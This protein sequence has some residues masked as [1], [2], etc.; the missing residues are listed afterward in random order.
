MASDYFAALMRA[1]GLAPVPARVH[2]GPSP[3]E[4]GIVE[5]HA[6]PDAAPAQDA[7]QAPDALPAAARPPDALPPGAT[8]PAA[9]PEAPAP[10]SA[11]PGGPLPDR[12]AAPMAHRAPAPGPR[13][14]AAPMRRDAEP[15]TPADAQEAS[16]QSMLRVALNWVHGAPHP[17]VREVPEATDAAGAAGPMPADADADVLPQPGVE[18]APP[19]IASPSAPAAPAAAARRAARPAPRHA[20]SAQPGP[21]A[22]P[23]AA[24]PWP[25]MPAAAADA[26][27]DR[28]E[29]S[30]GAI[31]LSVEAPPAQIAPSPS[32]PPAPAAPTAA[33]GAGPR[34]GDFDRRLLR[35]L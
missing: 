6:L 14:E 1:S 24:T 20:P 26:G 7:L 19:A 2:A 28:L 29:I 25:R 11:R 33:R 27:A 15:A 31:H 34:R 35:H 3:A 4:P 21:V 18:S 16:R 17:D 22:P 13:A 32:P 30:I 10:P 23:L 12:A 8:V 9:R 5:E